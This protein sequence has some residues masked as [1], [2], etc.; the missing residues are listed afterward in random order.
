MFTLSNQHSLHPPKCSF[1]RKNKFKYKKWIGSVVCHPLLWRPFTLEHCTLHFACVENPSSINWS[2]H[3]GMRFE[4]VSER[5]YS[6][7]SEAHLIH[8]KGFAHTLAVKPNNGNHVQFIKKR[9]ERCR[10]YFIFHYIHII[11][12]LPFWTALRKYEHVALHSIL[13]T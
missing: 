13:Q 1:L 7:H 10:N 3:N 8:S 12:C 5:V 4:H 6:I 9:T 11:N 2:N